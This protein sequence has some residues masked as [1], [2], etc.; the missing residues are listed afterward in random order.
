MT[1]KVISLTFQIKSSR[2][3]KEREKESA[4][5]GNKN[6]NEIIK[7]EP[8]TP[9]VFNG[10]TFLRLYVAVNRFEYAKL[11]TGEYLYCIKKEKKRT[12]TNVKVPFRRNRSPNPDA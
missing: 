5:K 1:T 12:V 8:V 2:D 10:I 9:S 11:Y 6:T 3:E 7:T 4:K